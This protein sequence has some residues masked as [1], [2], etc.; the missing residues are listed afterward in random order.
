MWTTEHSDIFV[1]EIPATG[2]ISDGVWHE[3]KMSLDT[4]NVTVWIDQIMFHRQIRDPDKEKLTQTFPTSDRIFFLGGIPADMS[5]RNE[6]FGFF[7]SNFVGCI[8]LLSSEWN[9]LVNDFSNF[10][11]ENVENCDLY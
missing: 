2:Q 7:Q 9:P 6:T 4:R 1:I 5:L 11:G 3:I 10:N 8:E